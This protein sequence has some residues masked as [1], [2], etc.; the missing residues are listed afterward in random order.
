MSAPVASIY[1]ATWGPLIALLSTEVIRRIDLYGLPPLTPGVDGSP[2]RITMSAAAANE[3][4]APPRINAIPIEFPFENTRDVVSAQ[5]ATQPQLNKTWNPRSFASQGKTFLIQCWGMNFSDRVTPAS[6]PEADYEAAQALAEI[7]WQSAQA[8]APGVWRTT[9]GKVDRNPS[10]VRQG[11][12]IEFDLAFGT[13]IV[14]T[15]LAYA[16]I[17]T[18]GVIDVNA[19][20]GGVVVPVTEI[21]TT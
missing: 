10:I 2:G 6:D 18:H 3:I 16:P 20:I 7:V 9:S 19:N 5:G 11:H 15:T 1:R 12:I 13:P 4:S 14:D 8:I 21:T 17:G